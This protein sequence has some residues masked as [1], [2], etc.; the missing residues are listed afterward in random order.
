MNV[1]SDVTHIDVIIKVLKE[2]NKNKLVVGILGEHD[3]RINGSS[4]AEVGAAHEFGSPA[5]NLPIRSFLRQPLTD[6]LEE[7]LEKSG[8]FNKDAFK[9]VLK[10][11]KIIP[12]L[13]KIGIVCEQ[14]VAEAFNSGGFGKWAPWKGDY[15]SSTGNILVDSTQLRDSITSEVR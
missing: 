9:K 7:F 5:R 6:H 11:Q 2:A 4:N 10:E 1:K 15:Q 3:A 12:W 14:V 13:K 8:L